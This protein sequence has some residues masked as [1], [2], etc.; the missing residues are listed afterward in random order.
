MKSVNLLLVLIALCCTSQVVN[1][2]YGYGSQRGQRRGYT[3]PPSPSANT[4]SSIN[5][6][7]PYDQISIVLPKCVEAFNLDDFEKEIIKGLLLKNF[8]SRNIIL[9][10]KDTSV[11]DKK[12]ELTEIDK[13][14]YKDLVLILSTEEV[15]K[16]KLMDFSETR[17]DK[18]QKKKKKKENRKKG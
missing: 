13:I 18:K 11:E 17:E 2:Q 5:L 16:F 10:D 8:E 15:E 7:D 1:A 6:K 4:D 14:F 12:K 9:G 3:P